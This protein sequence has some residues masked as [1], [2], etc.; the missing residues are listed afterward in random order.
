MGGNYDLVVVG[1]GLSTLSFL[2]AGGAPPS[3]VV[4]EYGDRPGG[5]LSPA[6]PSEEFPEATSLLDIPLPSAVELRSRTTAVGLI[7]AFRPGDSHTILARSREGTERILA[8]RVLIASG[9]LEITRENAQIPGSR[10]A[11]VFT[12]V[13]AHQLLDR[14]YVPGR[15][16]VIHGEGRYVHLTGTR[17]QK[18]GAEII[19]IAPSRRVI[20]VQGPVRVERV[21]V[22]GSGAVETLEADTLIY[23]SGLVANTH[24]L[25]GSGLEL[26]VDGCVKTDARH[27]TNVDGVFAIGAC[28]APSLDH[29]GSIAMGRELAEALRKEDA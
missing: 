27:A 17:L 29:E 5:L 3:T 25:V 21:L 13:M 19:P 24:W 1:A 4:V 10:P 20:E 22:E 18:A 11:G 8:R 26:D 16:I 23:A 7:P 12:P 14:G 15:R 2:A 9:G 6:L 28:V